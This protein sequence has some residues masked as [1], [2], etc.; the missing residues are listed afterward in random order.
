[1]SEPKNHDPLNIENI[2]VPADVS[3]LVDHGD[4]TRIKNA[5]LVHV[6]E[7]GDHVKFDNKTSNLFDNSVLNET[8]V[9]FESDLESDPGCKADTKRLKIESVCS[10]DISRYIES[11]ADSDLGCKTEVQKSKKGG[12]YLANKG[13]CSKNVL[14]NG[15]SVYMAKCQ[16]RPKETEGSTSIIDIEGDEV[17]QELDYKDAYASALS[18]GVLG[19]WNT[20]GQPESNVVGTNAQSL[21]GDE[22]WCGRDLTNGKVL[23]R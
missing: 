11:D 9:E 23:E 14:D 21:P 15:M 1:M 3:R 12:A 18:K 22:K 5:S 7:Y 16:V 13:H 6:T 17:G 2:R 20:L 8:E 19:N 4:K 10:T